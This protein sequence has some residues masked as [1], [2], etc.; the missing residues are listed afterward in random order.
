METPDVTKAQ[1]IAVV[2]GLLGFGVSVGL[3]D[4][5]TQ[6]TILSA[7][8]FVLPAVLVLADAMI[9][10]A[11]AENLSAIVASRQPDALPL[12]APYVLGQEVG[13]DAG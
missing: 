1:I 5:G 2:T 8:S 9:R 3:I 7:F 13:E 11:R 6:A 12:P 4:E 10:K